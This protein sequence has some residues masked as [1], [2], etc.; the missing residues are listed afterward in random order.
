MTRLLY[1][2]ENLVLVLES[3]LSAARV[4][5][6]VQSG[7]WQLP[8]ALAALLD[9]AAQLQAVRLGRLVVI[10]PAEGSA[11]LPGPAPADAGVVELSPRQREV[12][13]GLADGLTHPQ[14]AARLGL[15]PR[16]V[17]LHARQ[18][19][20]RFGTHSRVQ[21]VLRGLSLGFCKAKFLSRKE[22]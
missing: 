6:A 2:D 21:T 11:A 17:D 16:T 13:Q 15:H 1:V 9:P 12:L 10:A 18:L 20:N 3:D 22:K 14:I 4:V 19:Q 8:A 5:E 7:Q